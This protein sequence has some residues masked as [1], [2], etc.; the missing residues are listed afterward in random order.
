MIIYKHKKD[1][2][3]Y[4]STQKLQGKIIGFVPTMGALHNGH[5]SLITTAK[6]E[7]D[8]VICSIFVNPTQFNNKSDFEKYPITID[9]DVDLLESNGCDILY[10]P[11]VADIYDAG[12]ENLHH[13]DLGAIETVYDGPSRPGHFQGV[14]NVVERLFRATQPNKAYFGLK[15]YQQCMVIK[16]LVTIMQ[17]EHQLELHFCETLRETTGLAMSSRNMRLT[18]EQRENIAP[19]IYEAMSYLKQLISSDN[20]DSQLAHARNMVEAK[21]LVIDYFDIADATT[22]APIANWD[23][24]KSIVCLVAAF[25]GE[26]RLIDNMVLHK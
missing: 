16:K 20:V 15:D 8:I 10:L 23:G 13:Y 21:G 26:V 2:L 17:W 5:I 6:N 14:C 9:S 24:E 1:L 3:N 22:L 12:I 4:V 19:I 18:A 11:T 7:T 25:C